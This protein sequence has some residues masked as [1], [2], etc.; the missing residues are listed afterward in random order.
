LDPNQLDDNGRSALYYLLK[1]SKGLEEERSLKSALVCLIRK[2]NRTTHHHVL[3]LKDE[4]NTWQRGIM[5]KHAN[6][7]I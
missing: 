2:S 7:T 4:I 5:L 1:F 3:E 6:I